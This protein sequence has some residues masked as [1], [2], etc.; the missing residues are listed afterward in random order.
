MWTHPVFPSL[1][2]HQGDVDIFIPSYELNK[3]HKFQLAYKNKDDDRVH[4][5]N[6]TKD[7]DQDG[8]NP[9]TNSER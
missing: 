7:Q 5:G 1:T 3:I 2:G 6:Q 8:V 9:R 4:D